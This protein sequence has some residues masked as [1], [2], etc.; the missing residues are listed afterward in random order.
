MVAL[1]ERP[2]IALEKG[3]ERALSIEEIRRIE[4]VLSRVALIEG[5]RWQDFA[6]CTE[7][8]PELFFPNGESRAYQEQINAAKKVCNTCTAVVHCDRGADNEFGIWAG[9]TQTERRRVR[10][11][12]RRYSR[13]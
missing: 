11:S 6:L 13:A 2:I 12:N 3:G 1:L 8:D 5:K 4:V 9:M 7:A 10:R